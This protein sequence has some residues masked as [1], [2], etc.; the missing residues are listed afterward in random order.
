MK[1]NGLIAIA[2]LL[3]YMTSCKSTPLSEAETAGKAA[4]VF[5]ATQEEITV[6]IYKPIDLFPLC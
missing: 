5:R 1:I 3:V 4:L 6:R 2:C